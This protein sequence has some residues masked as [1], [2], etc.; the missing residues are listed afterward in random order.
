MSILGIFLIISS[1]QIFIKCTFQ[2]GRDL[3]WGQLIAKK[4]QKNDDSS[5]SYDTRKDAIKRELK[6]YIAMKSIDLDADPL[7]WWC[8]EG[9]TLFLKLFLVAEKDLICQA[10]R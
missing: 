2:S 1:D 8:T 10:T 6:N 4:S 7:V 3:L 9:R 5:S